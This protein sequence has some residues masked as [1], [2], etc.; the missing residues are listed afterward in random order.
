M[1]AR[2][3][4][5][6][7]SGP[8]DFGLGVLA[9]CRETGA[10]GGAVIN[11]TI[12]AGS[13]CL[14]VDGGLAAVLVM[15]FT[16]PDLG[17]LTLKLLGD[18]VRTDELIELLDRH[19]PFFAYRQLA[20]V[21]RAGNGAAHCGALS[22]DNAGVKV[23]GST[24][25]LGNGLPDE[26]ALSAVVQS[27]EGTA[28]SLERRLLAGLIAGRQC[29]PAVA[30]VRSATLTVGDSSTRNRTDLRIDFVA[31]PSAGADALDQLSAAVVAWEPL[32][33]YYQALP[34]DPYI[35]SWREWRGAD[36]TQTPL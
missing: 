17:P 22:P 5:S 10:I 21:P 9:R 7:F 24:I 12:A 15:A 16:N 20:V 14:F 34:E 18:T 13:R 28:G 25:V 1:L 30:E 36:D 23:E 6:A 11:S 2:R 3:K 27:V 33:S 4:T 26:R 29:L 8:A 32:V 31:D 35:G 19:D